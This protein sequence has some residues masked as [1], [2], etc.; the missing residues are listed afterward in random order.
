MTSAGY[1][2]YLQQ[3][4]GNYEDSEESDLSHQSGDSQNSQETNSSQEK[5]ALL[6]PWSR[7]LDETEQCHEAH[8]N[9]SINE[10]MHGNG[11][12]GN[13]ARVKAENALV[14]VYRNELRK[15]LLEYLQW[16]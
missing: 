9:A 7:I 1:N 8:L 12:S 11:D 10:Y 5:G 14:P 3:G 16:V 6:N 13:V 15:V 4:T 2:L